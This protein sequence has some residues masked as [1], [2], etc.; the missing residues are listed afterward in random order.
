MRCMC[1]QYLQGNRILIHSVYQNFIWEQSKKI[2]IT[3]NNITGLAIDNYNKA[4]Q[5]NTTIISL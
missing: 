5:K 2:E 4:K 1:G 3:K